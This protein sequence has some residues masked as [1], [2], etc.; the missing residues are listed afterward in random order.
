MTQEVRRLL[1]LCRR[2]IELVTDFA[3]DCR[4]LTRARGLR[5]LSLLLTPFAVFPLPL[6]YNGS[7]TGSP[8]IY[9]MASKFT[10]ITST[11]LAAAP[12][13]SSL[14]LVHFPKSSPVITHRDYTL[15]SIT[16]R[17]TGP[18]GRS[19]SQR[20][21]RGIRLQLALGSL[22][23]AVGVGN[24][25]AEHE[26]SGYEGAALADVEGRFGRPGQGTHRRDGDAP[27]CG[28]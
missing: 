6:R 13:L 26:A 24:A 15:P 21:W 23:E 9:F 28:E 8:T 17:R 11:L 25:R 3:T 27:F 7:S 16:Y 4:C 1:A 20:I 10:A 19:R 22:H 12:P 2:S 5:K 14:H 18:I